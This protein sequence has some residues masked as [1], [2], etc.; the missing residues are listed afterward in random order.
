MANSKKLSDRDLIASV[1]KNSVIYLNGPVLNEI[2]DL[3]AR[4]ESLLN[5]YDTDLAGARS[6][7]FMQGR[8][9]VEA[10]TAQDRIEMASYTAK[11]LVQIQ[12]N[13]FELVNATIERLGHEAAKQS[14]YM[15]GY[16]AGLKDADRD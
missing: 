10:E 5:Q 4:Y 14:A 2:L 9:E 15:N 6:D 7:G 13:T 8:K 3:A 16:A 1:E 11:L 12:S